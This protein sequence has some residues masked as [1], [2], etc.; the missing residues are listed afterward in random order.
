MKWKIA[1]TIITWALV[2]YARATIAPMVEADVAVTQ[3]QDSDF[4]YANFKGVQGAIQYLWLGYILPLT[5]FIQNIK[6]AVKANKKE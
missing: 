6:K 1:I 3:L 4:A 2:T 5:L